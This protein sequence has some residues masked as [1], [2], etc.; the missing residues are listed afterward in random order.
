MAFTTCDICDANEDKLADG[1]LTVLA[2]V[3]QQF[4]KRS[5]FFGPAV[6]LKVFED[7]VLVRSAL[8]T[9]GHG[10]VLVV[11]GGGSM[12]CALVGGLLGELAEKNAWAGVIV[13][14]C[15]RDVDEINACDI[16]VRA[17]ACHPRKSCKKGQGDSNVRVVFAGGAI[18]PGDW[19]YADADGIL[20]STQKLV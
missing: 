1:T 13:N 3:F 2:P 9:A 15:V 20:V 19:I 7:N 5:K 14:G 11:D 18:N 17:L 16:G 10:R 6:T 12:R 8:E 4:G